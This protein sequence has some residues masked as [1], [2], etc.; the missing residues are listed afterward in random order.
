MLALTS[1][2]RTFAY[3]LNMRANAH[4][5]LGFRKFDI[6]DRST[7][8]FKTSERVHAELT[9]LAI[10][11]PYANTTRRARQSS[12]GGLQPISESL[13]GTDDSDIR[14]SDRLFE[15]P[16]LRGVH[17]ARA[18][19]GGRSNYILTDT[20]RVLSWGANEYG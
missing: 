20:G 6:P 7:P 3:P 4:G 8:S 2:G 18:V 5:Q 17:V 16:A 9:P 1:R 11:D 13:K 15:I 19:A 14:W 10:V 12:D